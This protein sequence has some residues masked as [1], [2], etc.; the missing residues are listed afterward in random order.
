MSQLHFGFQLLQVCS[1]ETAILVT[2]SCYRELGKELETGK[3]THALTF[4]RGQNWTKE[5]RTK[6]LL[7]SELRTLFFNFQIQHQTQIFLPYIIRS[8]FKI[9]APESTEVL[10]IHTTITE[11]TDM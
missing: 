9:G 11:S 5:G 1:R 3:L 4:H 2:S 8:K 7:L 6:I 10:Q